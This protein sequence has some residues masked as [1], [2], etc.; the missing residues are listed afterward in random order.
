MNQFVIFF[1]NNLEKLVHLFTLMFNY[2]ISNTMKFSYFSHTSDL[3][4]NI[5][6]AT[7]LV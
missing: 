1:A 2:M 3:S 4:N 6:G 5:F 7:F